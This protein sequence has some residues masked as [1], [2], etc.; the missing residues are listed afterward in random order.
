M[1][2]L[3]RKLSRDAVVPERAHEND[4][5]ADLFSL[6]ET[7][8]PPNSPVKIK[9][10]ISIALPRGTAGFVWGKS[11]LESKGLKIM[12]GLIDEGYR[13]EVIVCMFNLTDKEIVL[14]EKQKI[15][16]LVVTP[17]HYP[18]FEEVAI[19]PESHR[20]EGGFGSTGEK[21][22]RAQK[23]KVLRK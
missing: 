8:I 7:R 23:F 16:Q 17:V 22:K 4:A 12:A 2:L 10:G 5:G 14:K 18:F 15:A 6:H 11:S 9:T 20:G 3:V 19:L 13:G 1:K 21:K